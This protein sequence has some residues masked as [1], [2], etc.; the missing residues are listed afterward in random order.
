MRVIRLIDSG[1]ASIVTVVHVD[2]IFAV[3]VKSRSD[4]FREDLNRLVPV[5]SLDELRRYSGCRFSRD[6]DS[7]TFTISQRV[8]TCNTAARFGISSGNNNPLATCLK[9]EGFRLV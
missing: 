1:S 8:F 6:W 7:G 5:N 3:E 4:Q 9:L 2:D